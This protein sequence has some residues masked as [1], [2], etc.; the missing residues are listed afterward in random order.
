MIDVIYIPIVMLITAIFILVGYLLISQI[1]TQ[2]IAGDTLSAGG[3]AIISES[4][5][6]YKDLWDGIFGFVFVGLS[7][8][9][10]VGA[11][12]IDVHPVFFILSLILLIAFIFVTAILSN[13]YYTLESNVAFSS[14]A[15]D[16]KIM[17]YI[18]N[19][20]PFYTVIE[21]LLIALVLYGKAR[22]SPI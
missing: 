15:E 19:H 13:S 1:N 22:S 9:A 14:F 3:Q 11:S 16:F 5:S 4:E 17:H 8:A 12:L 2:F 21:G 6:G 7:I 20:L 18:M 10:V